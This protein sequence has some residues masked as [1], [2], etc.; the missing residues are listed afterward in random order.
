MAT[1][2]DQIIAWLKSQNITANPGDFRTQQSDGPDQITVWNTATLGPQPT[3]AQLAAAP[4][5]VPVPAMVTPVQGRLALNASGKLAAV[6]AAVNASTDT[7]VQI[8]F[9]YATVWERANPI[10]A[11]LGTAIGL[12]P[13]DIDALFV[14]AAAN[15]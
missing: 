15:W 6:Q 1:L 5:Y 12:T 14:Q 7:S 10:V 11:S 2:N 13:A 4:V 8:W 3:D 9:E